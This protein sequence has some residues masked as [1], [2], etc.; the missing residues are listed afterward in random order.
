MLN[1]SRWSG[2]EA[3][4]CLLGLLVAAFVPSGAVVVGIDETIARR[5]GAK[6]RARGVYHDSVRFSRGHFVKASSLR[7]NSLMLLAP[8]LFV[9]RVWGLPFLTALATS[10]RYA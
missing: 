6:I 8:V 3:S 4:R 2:Q 1:H 9:E 5:W 7:W 10:E